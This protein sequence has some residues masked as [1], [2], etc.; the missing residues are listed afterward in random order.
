MRS[1]VGIAHLLDGTRALRTAVCL[2]YVGN[3]G[4]S[5]IENADIL[6]VPFPRILK[7]KFLGF[8]QH[9]EDDK[10]KPVRRKRSIAAGT[11]S[12]EDSDA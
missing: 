5:I 2:F 8:K 10:E 12:P 7:D 4:I 11:E 9:R 6:G 1:F 3:E